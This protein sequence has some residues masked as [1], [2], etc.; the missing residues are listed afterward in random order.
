MLVK[1]IRT[2]AQLLSIARAA[3]NVAVRSYQLLAARMKECGNSET[4]ALFERMCHEEQKH[5]HL[6]D[7]WAELE[8]IELDTG[9]E[10]FAW[11][12]P[13]VATH[14]DDEATDPYASTPYKALAFAVHNEERMFR[15]YTYVAANADNDTVRRYAEI[16]AREELA[17]SSILRAQRRLA[18]HAE[19]AAP[20]QPIQ[21]RGSQ[22][23]TLDDL[24][25][26]T[27]HMEA[28]LADFMEH[29]ADEAGLRQAVLATREVAATCAQRLTQAGKPGVEIEQAI[30]GSGPIDA[31]DGD[32]PQHHTIK[33]LVAECARAFAFYDEV[34]ETAEDETVMREAQQLTETSLDRLAVVQQC[35]DRISGALRNSD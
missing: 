31:P 2:A 27:A 29:A 18:Y 35:L 33:R 1:D 13:Q 30:A 21:L 16:L 12:D 32:E 24:L 5:E 11:E 6:L 26:A 14:Y 15:Y 9:I 4:A 20:R 7:D 34:V 22:V 19:R 3:E 10:P 8:G 17:H 23:H 28:R 25:S